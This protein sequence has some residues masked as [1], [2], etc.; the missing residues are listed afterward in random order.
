MKI[1]KVFGVC[2]HATAQLVRIALT[3]SGRSFMPLTLEGIRQ[4][5]LDDLRERLGA[6]E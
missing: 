2:I 5:G 1:P 3:G 4:A 6:R